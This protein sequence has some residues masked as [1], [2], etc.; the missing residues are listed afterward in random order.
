MIAK[1]C[2]VL[3]FVVNGATTEDTIQGP[4]NIIVNRTVAEVYLSPTLTEVVQVKSRSNEAKKSWTWISPVLIQ[5][6]LPVCPILQT[7]PYLNKDG[8][9]TGT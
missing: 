7:G 2:G 1:S 3:V 8:Q 4:D 9:K 5:L 6:D